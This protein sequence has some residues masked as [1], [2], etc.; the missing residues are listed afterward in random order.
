M[1]GKQLRPILFSPP[2]V[3]AILDGRKTQTRRVVKPQ[4]VGDCD[5]KMICA[6]VRPS[7]GAVAKNNAMSVGEAEDT[8]WFSSPYI[9]GDILWVRETFA[10]TE[11]EFGTPIV[12]YRAGGHRVAAIDGDGNRTSFDGKIGAFEEPDAWRP[13]IFMPHW[14]CRI[15]LHVISVDIQ[16]VQ[17]ITGEDAVAEG[18][19]PDPDYPDLAFGEFADLWD[20]LNEPRGYGWH[21]NPWVWVYRFGVCKLL[22]Q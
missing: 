15:H 1:I 12:T 6:N 10:E 22:N 4:P 21:S 16:R 18:L 19:G 17:D 7:D 14:A 5:V 9:E 11:D 13:S 8:Q 20:M 3:R 2:M